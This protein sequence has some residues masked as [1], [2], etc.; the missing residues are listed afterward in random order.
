MVDPNDNLFR[1]TGM[2]GAREDKGLRIWWI[3]A[4]ATSR[5]ITVI[6]WSRVN[7]F[8][9]WLRA[10]SRNDAGRSRRS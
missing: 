4:R 10:Q 1:F 9:D 3:W 5:C 8:A 6:S 7:E 2:G